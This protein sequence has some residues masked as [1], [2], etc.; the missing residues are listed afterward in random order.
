[1]CVKQ[2]SKLKN[3]DAAI[4]QQGNLLKDVITGIRDVRNK[5]QIK[6]KEQIQLYIQTASKNIYQSIESILA[7]Q[8]N[9]KA[10]LFVDDKVVNSISAVIGNDKFYVESEQPINSGSQK[11]DLIK[12]LEHQK[13]FLQSVEKKLSNQKFVANAKPEILA[14]EQKKKADAL[15][16]IKAIEESLAAL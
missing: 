16:R 3:T 14:L 8:L 5:N 6:P 1:M 9:A 10:I 7:K 11:E 4:L 12:D 15:G 13:G 2:L